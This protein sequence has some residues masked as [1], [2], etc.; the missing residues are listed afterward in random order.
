M[1]TT[2]RTVLFCGALLGSLLGGCAPNVE[3]SGAPAASSRQPVVSSPGSAEKDD[4]APDPAECVQGAFE[5]G[6]TC[7]DLGGSD[8]E[9]I[10][11]VTAQASDACAQQGL[12]LSELAVDAVDCPV[13]SGKATYVCCPTPAPSEGPGACQDDKVGTDG[14]VDLATLESMAATRCAEIGS[15]LATASPLPG[16]PSGQASTA[17]ISCCPPAP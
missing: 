14:C 9:P 15:V 13:G 17:M 4:P 2:H 6:T 10:A 1:S 3:P 7:V 8:K 12:L 16:C 11:G 5:G